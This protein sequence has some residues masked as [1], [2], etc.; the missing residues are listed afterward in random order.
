MVSSTLWILPNWNSFEIR[1]YKGLIATILSADIFK[2][3][4]LSV[5]L[6]VSVSM[7]N[8][9]LFMKSELRPRSAA[10]VSVF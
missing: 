6:I 3:I 4:S 9:L 8:N 1:A 2:V 5:L 7:L 10:S